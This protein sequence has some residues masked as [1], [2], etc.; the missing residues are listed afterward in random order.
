MKISI[1]ITERDESGFHNT[2]R[3]LSI[4]VMSIN[5]IYAWVVVECEGHEHKFCLDASELKKATNA[6]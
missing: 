4:E 3:Y 6:L 1:P 2:G 5:S